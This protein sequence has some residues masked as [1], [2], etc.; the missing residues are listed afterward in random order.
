MNETV[1]EGKGARDDRQR[2]RIRQT[3]IWKLR[4]CENS[5]KWEKGARKDR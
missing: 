5:G 2:D 3:C 1:S 4:E